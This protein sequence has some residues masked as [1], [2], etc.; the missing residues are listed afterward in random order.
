MLGL[1]IWDF[2]LA[3]FLIALVA[4]FSKIIRSKKI[5]D[6]TLNFY[7]LWGFR[8]RMLIIVAYSILSGTILAGDQIVLY[9]GEGEHF[10]SLI[11]ENTDNLYLLFT[12]GGQT[13]D[14]IANEKG[15]LAMESNYL[16][17][18][19]SIVLCL[20]TGSKFFLINI[21]LG[22]LSF[23]ASWQLFKVFYTLYPQVHKL[24]AISTLAIPSVT[25][26]SSGINK[27]T[28]CMI[29]IGILSKG[30]FDL[31][32]KNR[33]ILLNSFLTIIG[34]YFVYTIKSYII[35]SYLP[36]LLYFLVRYKVTLTN[37]DFLRF[38]LR[39]TVPTIFIL[40]AAYIFVNSENL[41]KE[42]S[43][44]K[45]LESVS[46][47]QGAFTGAWNDSAGS[48]F[49]L[50]EFD[51]SFGGFVRLTPIAIVTTF[52]RP[53]IWEC[54]SLIMYLTSFE[55]MAMLFFLLK[56]FF[57]KNGIKTFF[58]SLISN[59]VVLYCLGF[60]LLFGVFVGVSTFN[61]GSLTRYKIPCI[62][63]YAVGLS[64]IY[65]NIK[66]NVIGIPKLK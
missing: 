27:D 31:I 63:F 43:S 39:V 52:F 42:F 21:I 46:R 33:Q 30:L 50:G 14:Q 64:I 29:G 45:I 6:P 62:P 44:E 9:F 56:I 65:Y 8:Y 60:A 26:W 40:S 61:F 41:F 13:I 15:Y 49:T 4:Y 57:T 66:N 28:L 11:K 2:I 51:G 3:P 16:V 10:A 54:K 34:I 25:F 36:F 55:G 7:Y 38:I 37:N 1:T 20:L 22:Y 32:I 24:L 5:T 59:S 47:T 58:L 53:F 48:N 12:K 19:V 23:L 35:L 17:V 18:K